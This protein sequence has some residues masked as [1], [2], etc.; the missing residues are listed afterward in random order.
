ML[1]EALQAMCL[2]LPNTFHRNCQRE[3]DTCAAIMEIWPQSACKLARTKYIRR[4]MLGYTKH[5]Q[6]IMV[7]CLSYAQRKTAG[8]PPKRLPAMGGC[9]HPDTLCSVASMIKK[10]PACG[11]VMS[12]AGFRRCQRT[13][14]PAKIDL[15]GALAILQRA[16][17][18]RQRAMA[19]RT[20]EEIK[21]PLR[22]RCKRVDA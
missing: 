19:M 10:A 8:C 1:V 6:K 21:K 7:Y 18:L 11:A 14:H 12:R 9:G 17:P 4:K 22:A 13:A 3:P 15:P 16:N 20:D 2:A 5:M